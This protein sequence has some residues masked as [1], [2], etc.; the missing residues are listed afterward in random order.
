VAD[1]GNGV[2]RRIIPEGLVT[3][4]A[5][6]AAPAGGS[7]AGTSGTAA[8]SGTSSGSSSGGGA[9]EGWFAG[10]LILAAVA[11]LFARGRRQR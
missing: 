7:D 6:T 11:R 5:L 9:I 1:T 10:M 8:G 4:L 2:I 3:T